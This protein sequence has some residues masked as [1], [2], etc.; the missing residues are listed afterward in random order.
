MAA[1]MLLAAGSAAAD[2]TAMAPHPIEALFPLDAVRLDGGPLKA[3]QEQNRKYRLRLDPD[4]LLSRF[5][6]EAGLEPKAKP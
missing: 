3:Q 6:S 4:K 1:A 5:R 2:T